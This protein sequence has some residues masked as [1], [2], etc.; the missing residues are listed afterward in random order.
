M[1]HLQLI[2]LLT[3]TVLATACSRKPHKDETLAAHVTAEKVKE[4]WANQT[5]P[6]E[7]VIVERTREE[8]EAIG[9]LGVW[10]DAGSEESAIEFH[11]D[12]E[13]FKPLTPVMVDSTASPRLMYPFRADAHLGDTLR[14]TPPCGPQLAGQFVSIE[15]NNDKFIVKFELQDFTSLLRLRLKSDNIEDKLEAII[16]ADIAVGQRM[17]KSPNGV[18]RLDM[19]SHSASIYPDCMLNNGMPH[20]FHLMYTEESS[21]ARITLK[22]NGKEYRVITVIPPLREGSITELHVMLHKGKLSVGSSWVDSK[23]PFTKPK[24]APSDSIRVGDFL[25]KDG[26]TSATC[27]AQS[28]ALVIESNGRH[29]KAVALTDNPRAFVFRKKDFKTGRQFETVDGKY[30]EG[31]FYS[32]VREEDEPAIPFAPKVVY[33]RQ[34]AFGERNGA[35]LSIRMFDTWDDDTRKAF[36]DAVSFGTA[37]IPSLFELATLAQEL[38]TEGDRLPAEF[39]FPDGFC[40]SS[41]ESGDDTYYALNPRTF[42]ISAYNSKAYPA[43]RLRLFYLF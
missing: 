22:V 42:R 17:T 32:K 24:E 3:L 41:C 16:L 43:T 19:S 20:D 13:S 38:M 1:K 14:L 18:Y 40:N 11:F 5:K 30:K 4:V 12:G 36:E 2:L 35:D 9:S 21:E 23:F 29:G 6:L 31:C 7:I 27:N 26:S 8:L 25:Q 39:D 28:I 34:A 33:H 37:Y 10:V 15:N